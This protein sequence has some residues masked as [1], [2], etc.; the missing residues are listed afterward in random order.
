MKKISVKIYDTNEEMNFY[1]MNEVMKIELLV[2]SKE[3]DTNL[4][5]TT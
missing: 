1:E 5:N 4:D 3:I 2:T